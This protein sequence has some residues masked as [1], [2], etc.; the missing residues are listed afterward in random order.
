MTVIIINKKK[1]AYVIC[2]YVY[3][4][5]NITLLHKKNENTI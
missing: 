1:K 5:M 2:M 4:C 3:I